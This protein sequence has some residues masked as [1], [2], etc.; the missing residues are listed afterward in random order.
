MNDEM[1]TGIVRLRCRSR[2]KDTVARLKDALR[3]RHLKLVAEIDHGG[4]AA[5]I[6]MSMPA[7]KLFIFGSSAAGTPI[8]LSAPLSALD[9]PLK[10]LV[11]EDGEAVWIA[12]NSPE[13][14]QQRHG[15]PNALLK[16]VS[17][18]REICEQAAQPTSH[19]V[20]EPC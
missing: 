15:F 6:G 19:P 16:N 2:F 5:L 20:V 11:F 12:Y 10:A 8:M 4:D 13:Y 7:T 17:G 3:S 14:L 1:G 18:V 9:L